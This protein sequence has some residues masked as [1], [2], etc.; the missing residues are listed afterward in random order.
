M[1]ADEAEVTGQTARRRWIAFFA[2]LPFLAAI[3]AGVWL[4]LHERQKAHDEQMTEQVTGA[5][6]GCV[7]SVR[8]DAPDVWGV[9]RSLEHM[10]RMER[11]TRDRED[12]AT[13]DERARFARLAADAARGC[14]ELGSLM[15]ESQRSGSELYFGVPAKLAQPP[16]MNDPERWYRRVLPLSR[17]EVLELT[18][19]IRLMADA[20]NARRTERELMAQELPIEGRG[21]S[22]LA[23][24]VELTPLPREREM[25]RTEVWPM[26]DGVFVM[27]R[28]SIPRVPCD[29]RYINRLS[30][31]NEFVQTVSWEGEV[32]PVR[33]LERPSGVL[34][35][36]S[37][38]PT[39]DGSLWAVGTDTRDEGIVGRYPPDEL[40]PRLA[41]LG[42]SVDATTNIVAVG[43]GVA[44]FPSDGSAWLAQDDVGSVAQVETTPPPVVVRE[45]RGGA[46]QGIEIE[47]LGRLSVFG[48]EEG[49]WTSRLS[50]AEGDDVLLRM[51][52]AHMRVRDVTALRALRTGRAVGL[53]QR[54]ADS[55]DAI[56]ITATFGRD[57]LADPAAP[58]P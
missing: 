52:D 19:Q 40:T 4:Y 17:P 38:T 46:P 37:F 50:P 42:A 26:P 58:S 53:L 54:A 22:E 23:R 49:G 18:R 43:G 41:P 11:V 20:I 27:R 48:D 56:A 35:W 21:P 31:F 5:A 6:F 13:A 33:A 45:G 1:D 10:S 8:G 24:I 29:T 55:P 32:G 9:E 12:P 28:G 14:E 39:P 34:Y 44:V 7:A 57:W 3:A 15:M 47:E 2:T 51:I 16:D 36:A 30:C 25:P